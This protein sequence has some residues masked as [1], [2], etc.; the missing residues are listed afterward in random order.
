MASDESVTADTETRE[1][2][3]LLVL[4]LSFYLAAPAAAVRGHDITS[5]LIQRNTCLILLIIH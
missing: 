3:L 2:G 5:N 1:R 4:S